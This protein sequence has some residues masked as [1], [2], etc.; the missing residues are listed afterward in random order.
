MLATL[1]IVLTYPL[2]FFRSRHDLAIEVLALRHQLMVLKR[3]SRRPKFRRSD[4]CLWQVLMT[5]PRPVESLDRGRVIEIPKVGS[6]HH[7]YLR[8]AA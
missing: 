6:L 4:R 3:Q 7:Q 1:W 5:I 8:Q 2:S